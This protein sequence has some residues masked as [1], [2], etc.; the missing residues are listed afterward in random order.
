MVD[1]VLPINNVIA[2]LVG[3]PSLASNGHG[4][5]SLSATSN[6][7]SEEALQILTQV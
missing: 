3:L 5:R 6:E 4:E 7:R 2:P 1:L